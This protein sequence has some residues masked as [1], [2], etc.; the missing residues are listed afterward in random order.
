MTIEHAQS[1]T[2][3]IPGQ[4][5]MHNRNNS[6]VAG[7]PDN[8]HDINSF[9]PVSITQNPEQDFNGRASAGARSSQ[10]VNYPGGTVTLDATPMR[11]KA[12]A[13]TANGGIGVSYSNVVLAGG[14]NP[15][16]GSNNPGSNYKADFNSS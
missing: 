13:N 2:A 9:Q 16:E 3:L 6:V 12:E 11:L 8:N 5:A 14:M 10:G 7:T 1:N 4:P 15:R